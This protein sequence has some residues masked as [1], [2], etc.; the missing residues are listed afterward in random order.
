MSVVDHDDHWAIAGQ[1][2]EQSPTAHGICSPT[3]TARA[4][5]R[6]AARMSATTSALSAPSSRRRSP[7]RDSSP[8][9][10]ITASRSGQKAMHTVREASTGQHRRLTRE[11]VYKLLGEPRFADTGFPDHRQEIRL[12]LGLVRLKVARA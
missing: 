2:L 1:C 9:A 11:S 6:A 7:S 8:A 3:L 12:A 10:W 5:P 4:S